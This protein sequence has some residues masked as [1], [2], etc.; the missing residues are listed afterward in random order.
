MLRIVKEKM[1]PNGSDGLIPF[2]EGFCLSTD[3]NRPTSVATGSKLTEV[4]S[5]KVYLYDEDGE[6]WTEQ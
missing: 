6:A 1:L 3:T 4:D 5:G 2:I